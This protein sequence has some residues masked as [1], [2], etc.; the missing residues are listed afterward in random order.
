MTCLA[1]ERAKT[2]VVWDLNAE[3]NMWTWER[4]IQ[5]RLNKIANLG[6]S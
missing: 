1:A 5:K 3:G 6:A 2:E 4:V